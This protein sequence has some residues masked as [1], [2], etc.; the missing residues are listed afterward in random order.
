MSIK[1]R[2]AQIIDAVANLFEPLKQPSAVSQFPFQFKTVQKQFMH[3]TSLEKQGAI[4]ALM[5][6][7][8]DKGGKPDADAVGFIDERY[9]ISVIVVLKEERGGPIIIDQSSDM[10]YSVEALVNAN[11]TLGVEGVQ[12]EHTK[13]EDWRVSEES[14]FPILIIKFRLMV[15]HRYHATE[16]V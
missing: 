11:K 10:H 12:P 5:L 4:P 1:H 2:R 14:L 8:G 6:M 15:V 16:S 9:P 13:L 7:M 3:W